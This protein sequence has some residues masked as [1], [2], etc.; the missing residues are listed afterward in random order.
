MDS[1]KEHTEPFSSR[2]RVSR[3]RAAGASIPR[4]RACR[5]SSAPFCGSS[6][7][8]GNTDR[9][10]PSRAAGWGL[11]RPMSQRPVPRLSWRACGPLLPWRRCWFWSPWSSRLAA[12]ARHGRRLYRTPPPGHPVQSRG[13]GRPMDQAF[14]HGRKNEVQQ[15]RFQLPREGAEADNKAPPGRAGSPCR[16]PRGGTRLAHSPGQ[17]T[18]GRRSPR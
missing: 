11:G 16:Y 13:C 3:V 8:S 5:F 6:S 15:F 12:G 9:S 7:S 17:E 18:T 14:S 4:S 2:C 10:D 1:G